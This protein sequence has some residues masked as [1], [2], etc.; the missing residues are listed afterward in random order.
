MRSAAAAALAMALAM[1]ATATQQ[2]LRDA[3]IA[4]RCDDGKVLI[5]GDTIDDD[6]IAKLGADGINRL[7]LVAVRAALSPGEATF[8]ITAQALN[9]LVP[10]AAAGPP[11]SVTIDQ[12]VLLYQRRW[13]ILRGDRTRCNHEYGGYGISGD[14]GRGAARHIAVAL[15][16][17]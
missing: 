8:E 12:L 4:L 6:A 10:Q 2:P 3:R 1:G 17:S 13:Q 15:G 16:T 5:V 11:V 9:T 7:P 14:S